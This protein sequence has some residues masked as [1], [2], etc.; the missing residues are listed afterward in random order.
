MTNIIK[1]DFFV[2][3]DIKTKMQKKIYIKNIIVKYI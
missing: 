2:N 1:N 3:N